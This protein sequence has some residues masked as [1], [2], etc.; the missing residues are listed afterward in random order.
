MQPRRNDSQQAGAEKERRGEGGERGTTHHIAAKK[1][2]K[3][4]LGVRT[5]KGGV[6]GLKNGAFRME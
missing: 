6:G 4:S 2:W 3:T 1:K 5:A